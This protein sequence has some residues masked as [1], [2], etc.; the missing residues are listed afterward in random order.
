[1]M[2]MKSRKNW[3]VVVLL[4]LGIIGGNTGTNHAIAKKNGYKYN[5]ETKKFEKTCAFGID[6]TTEDEIAKSNL[7]WSII[8]MI[9]GLVLHYTVIDR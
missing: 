4:A 6:L 5:K 3:I 9:A 8:G 1:M 7:A 2:N